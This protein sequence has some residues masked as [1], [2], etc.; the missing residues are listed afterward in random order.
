MSASTTSVPSVALITD[1]PRTGENPSNHWPFEASSSVPSVATVPSLNEKKEERPTKRA[2]PPWWERSRSRNRRDRRY[3]RGGRR[4]PVLVERPA[5]V[6]D[7]GPETPP[8]APIEPTATTSEA[9]PKAKPPETQKAKLL[10]LADSF[11]LFQDASKV[12][13]ASFLRDGRRETWPAD[14]LGALL[15]ERYFRQYHASPA[16][17]ALQETVRTLEARALYDGPVRPVFLR[18]GELGGATYLDLCNDAWQSVRIN[19]KGWQTGCFEG[20]HLV[21]APGMQALHE[22]QRGGSLDELRAFLPPQLTD[23]AWRLVVGFLTVA[24]RPQGPYPILVLHGPGGVGKSSFVQMLRA[25]VD[26]SSV[27]LTSLPTNEK[28]LMIAASNSWLSVFD[29]VSDVKASMSDALCRLATGGGLRVRK[30]YTDR[31][32]SMFHLCRPMILNGI[33]RFIW[34]EDLLSRTLI[35]ELSAMPKDARREEWELLDAFEAARGRLLGALLDAAVGAMHEYPN[36]QLSDGPRLMDFA[37]WGIAIE[38]TLQWPAGAFMRSY[39]RMLDDGT[40]DMIEGSP[41]AAAVVALA[42]SPGAEWR[43]TPD[44]L[45]HLVR[46][47]VPP[48]ATLPRS[49]RGVTSALERYG[50]TLKRAGVTIERPPRGKER[51]IVLRR[52]PDPVVPDVGGADEQ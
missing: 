39:A 26:P 30:L 42:S 18:V 46:A 51:I 43:G 11:T 1:E 32:E 7:D 31:A 6:A 44:E 20:V 33:G 34:R 21:R 47:T 5:T 45:L 8:S 25:L 24:L 27:A 19:S 38:R 14:H 36:V 12:A 17:R 2:R 50:N 37:K 48:G 3:R 23:D 49:A 29:N 28:D 35:V 41:F 4:T 52:L 22:P 9:P 40:Q 15:L 13:Y 16:E 10:K